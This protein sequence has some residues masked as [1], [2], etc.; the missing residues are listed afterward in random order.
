MKATAMSLKRLNINRIKEALK[1]HPEG[2]K[3]SISSD[4]GLSVA[5]CGNLL[6]ELLKTGE[7]LE[8]PLGKSTGGRPSRRFKFNE[9]HSYIACIYI[10]SDTPT[11]HIS[12]A[13]LNL[14]GEI[15]DENNHYC[16]SISITEFEHI[17]SKLVETHPAITQLSFGI[18]GVV[19]NGRI[20]SCDYK[21]LVQFDLKGYFTEK[22]H[23]EVFV[24]NDVNAIAHGFYDLHNKKHDESLAF[25][26]Y[27]KNFRPG[28]GFIVNGVIL[29][30]FSDFSGEIGYMSYNSTNSRDDISFQ[31][32]NF[33]QNVAKTIAN[34]NCV[35]NPQFV[36]LS[37]R[38][39]DDLTFELIQSD[40]SPY[41]PEQHIPTLLYEEDFHLSYIRGL[42]LMADI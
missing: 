21:E 2:T 3:I 42:A 39:L 31:D 28:A 36:I 17:T 6:K 38:Q 13:I 24:E 40:L 18:P 11:L 5:T 33:T 23:L 29:R 27:P 16:P 9:N 35:L 10:N 41:F 4:T 15:I 32:E 20:L 12:Y 34:I 30:G 37:G 19:S 14:I 8:L 22:Y 26:F 1:H 7:V 25:L